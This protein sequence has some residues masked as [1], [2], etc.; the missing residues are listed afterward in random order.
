MELVL[1]MVFMAGLINYFPKLNRLTLTLQHENNTFPFDRHQFFS[2]FF[3]FL[4]DWQLIWQVFLKGINPEV[5]YM[6]K[7]APGGAEVHRASGQSLVE[8]EFKVKIPGQCDGK[9]FEFRA[10]KTRIFKAYMSYKK[11]YLWP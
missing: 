5:E 7:L 9:I 1:K 8:E 3:A 11:P 10:L 2:C 6:V 4:P